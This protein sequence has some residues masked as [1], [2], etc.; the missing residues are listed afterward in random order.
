MRQ[1]LFCV[2]LA[3]YSL[4]DCNF[5]YI[6]LKPVSLSG[7]KRRFRLKFPNFGQVYIY[8]ACGNPSKLPKLPFPNFCEVVQIRSWKRSN[9]VKH[10][11][12]RQ[13][14]LVCCLRS[15]VSRQ[16]SIQTAGIT[17]ASTACLPSPH[18]S[19]IHER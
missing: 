8:N 7:E 3:P 2:T 15:A 1:L 14:R 13:T 9:L 4:F 17:F 11:E 16:R 19:T 5:E 6:F 18:A 10:A 12:R